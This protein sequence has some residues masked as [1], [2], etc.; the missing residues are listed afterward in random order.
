MS[1]IK[2]LLSLMPTFYGSSGLYKVIKSPFLS[3]EQVQCKNSN[4]PWLHAL[5]FIFI[6]GLADGTWY[7]DVINSTLKIF[8]Q[9][10]EVL[11]KPTLILESFKVIVDSVE[12]SLSLLKGEVFKFQ[13]NARKSQKMRK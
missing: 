12:M 9:D 3:F 6:E 8:D 2:V 5:N 11:P 7:I 13:N 1:S 10:Q 4:L